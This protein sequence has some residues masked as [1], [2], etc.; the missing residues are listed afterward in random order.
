MTRLTRLSQEE[1]CKRYYG[2]DTICRL[3]PQMHIYTRRDE[4]DKVIEQWERRGD[5]CWYDITAKAKAAERLKEAEQELNKLKRRMQN[6]DAS[7][8]TSQLNRDT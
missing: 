1:F 3:S 5:G 8:L 4:N 6:G 7:T 2:L